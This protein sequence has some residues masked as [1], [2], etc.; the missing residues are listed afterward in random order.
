MIQRMPRQLDS[1]EVRI[2]GCLLEK[3]QATPEY[4]PLT[5]KALVTACNQSSN[6]YPVMRLAEGEV[7]LALRRLVQ[8]RLVLRDDKGRA[9]RWSQNIDRL[10][11]LD[12]ACK[13]ALTVLLLRGPQT[14]GEVRSRTARL[15]DFG[16]KAAA[17]AALAELAAPP[18]PVVVLLERNP[19]QKEARW[20]HRVGIAD[21]E[22][23]APAAP[24]QP[25]PAPAARE[26]DPELTMRRL[27]RL[28]QEIE[29]LKST[30]SRIESSD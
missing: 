4:Y 8:A 5:L 17:E 6:R 20:G 23:D 22:G 28:E 3:Q 11:G 18:D 19:G 1:V 14:A 30:L 15:H 21:P 25:R 7:G 12:A 16:S 9:T 26:L 10:L 2:I 24:P 13:A 29:K 27:D